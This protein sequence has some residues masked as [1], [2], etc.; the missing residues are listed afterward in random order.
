MIVVRLK[1]HRPAELSLLIHRVR[2]NTKLGL[3]HKHQQ[4]A[5][6]YAYVFEDGQ[7]SPKLR[8]TAYIYMIL[9]SETGSAIELNPPR[10]PEI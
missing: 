2:T 9:H 4:R 7:A 6:G 5:I 1:V 8:N 3:Y 10:K